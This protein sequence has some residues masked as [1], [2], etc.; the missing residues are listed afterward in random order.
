MEITNSSPK[1]NQQQPKQGEKQDR[2][3][4]FMKNCMYLQSK[5]EFLNPNEKESPKF[6]YSKHNQ[7]LKTVNYLFLAYKP[8][9][10]F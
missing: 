4:L 7:K 3:L 5:G 10:L 1:P 6:F 2:A 9:E 8:T